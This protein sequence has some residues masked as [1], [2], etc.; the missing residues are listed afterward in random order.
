VLLL[1]CMSLLLSSSKLDPS[2][3]LHQRQHYLLL[4]RLLRLRFHL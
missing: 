3:K 2:H 4:S 1:L